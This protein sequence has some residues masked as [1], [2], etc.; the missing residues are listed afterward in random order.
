MWLTLALLSDVVG[1]RHWFGRLDGGFRRLYADFFNA[2]NYNLIIQKVAN[3]GY[4][5]IFAE[6]FRV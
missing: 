5:C 4:L 6:N 1:L 2:F 3:S